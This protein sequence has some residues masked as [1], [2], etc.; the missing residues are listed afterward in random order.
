MERKDLEEL[1]LTKEQI[2]KTL[3][4]YHKEHDPVKKN[5]ETAQEDLKNEKI[6]VSTQETTIADLKKDLEGFKDVDV[7]GLEKKIEDLEKDIKDKDKEYQNKIA[8]RDFNDILKDSISAAKGINAK[9]IKALL[10]IDALKASKNQKEDI[11]DAIKKLTEADDSKM[12]FGPT[13]VRRDDP[14]GGIGGINQKPQADSLASALAEKY[15]S[16]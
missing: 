3:D 1:G 12:L 4:M 5:L 16:K 13:Q 11:A 7:S 15:N 6:K 9:A 10:D 2:D 8:D 14:I